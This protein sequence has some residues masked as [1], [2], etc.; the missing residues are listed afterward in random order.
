MKPNFS[1]KA[2]D[3]R[4]ARSEKGRARFRRY[5]QSALGVANRIMWQNN[6]RLYRERDRLLA[7]PSLSQPFFAEIA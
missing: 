5:K 3:A 6:R 2:R 4:Y 7:D 1:R